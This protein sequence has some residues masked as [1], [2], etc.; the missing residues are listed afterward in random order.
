MQLPLCQREYELSREISFIFYREKS[1][2]IINYYKMDAIVLVS[3][4]HDHP[5]ID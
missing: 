1:A 4:T 5:K 2:L 3:K